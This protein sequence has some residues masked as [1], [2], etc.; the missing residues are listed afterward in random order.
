MDISLSKKSEPSQLENDLRV[1]FKIVANPKE[2][3]IGVDKL[4]GKLTI[5]NKALKVDKGNYSKFQLQ[6]VLVNLLLNRLETAAPP[7]KRSLVKAPKRLNFEDEYPEW[8]TLI[9]NDRQ[10]IDLDYLLVKFGGGVLSENDIYSNMWTDG[11]V[12]HIRVQE[13][14]G[15]VGFLE[16]KLDKL[17][18]PVHYMY[19]LNSMKTNE[20]RAIQK[21]IEKPL[22]CYRNLLELKRNY[23]KRSRLDESKIA[24]RVGVLEAVNLLRA[25]GETVSAGKVK[26]FTNLLLGLD[27]DSTKAWKLHEKVKLD[28]T[29]EPSLLPD[30]EALRKV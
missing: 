24:I 23:D 4:F 13:F 15:S 12:D 1:I 28:C 20:V 25:F 11:R 26:T 14:V 8:A 19:L 6:Y 17:T 22:R 2:T 10:L 9:S 3:V 30:T 27:L 21:N 18:L 16:H 29:A 5:L 7:F